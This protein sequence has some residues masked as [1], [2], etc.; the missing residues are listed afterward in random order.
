MTN[1]NAVP[2]PQPSESAP[3]ASARPSRT[4]SFGRQAGVF[5][6]L[7]AVLL[8]GGYFRLLNLDWDEGEHLHPDER[9]MTMVTGAIR[10]PGPADQF[11]SPPPG[12]ESW[13]G[14]FDSYCSPLNP[15]SHD[16]FGSYAYGTFPLF[17]A[18]VAGEWLSEACVDPND[19]AAHAPALQRWLADL[20]FDDV[21]GCV[22][23]RFTGYG[24]IH[25]IGRVLSALADLGAAALLFFIGRRLYGQGVGWL[26]TALYALAAL[27]IQQSHFYTVDSF[28]GFF[29]VAAGY[30]VVRGS[31]GGSWLAF[32]LAG[33]TFGLALACKVSVWPFAAVIALAA[34]L[35]Y[36]R[37]QGASHLLDGLMALLLLI[38]VFLIAVVALFGIWKAVN[39]AFYFAVFVLFIGAVAFYVLRPGESAHRRISVDGVLLRVVLAGVCA[40]FA[41]RVAQPYA[42]VGTDFDIQQWQAPEYDWLRTNVPKIW[43]TLED[44]LPTPIKVLFLP[45]PR[46]IS[47]LA[48]VNKQLTGEADVPWG[49]QWTNRLPFVFPWVNMVVWGMGLPLG[50]AVWIAWAVAGWQLWRGKNR[51]QHFIPWAWV[52]VLFFYQGTQWVKSIRYLLPIYPFLILLGA[53]LVVRVASGKWRVASGELARSCRLLSAVYRLPLAVVLVGTLLWAWG[54][55]RIYAH[56]VTRNTASRWMVENIPTAAT[57]HYEVDGET[58]TQFLRLPPTFVYGEDG[59]SHL[60]SFVMPQ[61]GVVTGVTFT[62]LSDPESDATPETFQVILSDASTVQSVLARSERTLQLEQAQNRLGDAHFFELQVSPLQGGQEYYLITQV[63]GGAPVGTLYGAAAATL[64][65]TAGGMTKTQAV[66]FPSTPH[67]L[68]NDKSFHVWPFTLPENGAV[69]GVTFHHLEDP[70]ADVTTEHIKVALAADIR[71]RV[72]LAQAERVLDLQAATVD[73]QDVQH[74]EFQPPALNGDQEYYLLTQVVSGAP[75]QLDT[76]VIANEYPDDSLPTRVDGR[77]P[78]GGMYRGLQSAGDG[79]THWDLNEDSNKLSQALEWLD[80]AD[81]IALSSNRGYASIPRLPSRYPL[82]IEFYR[83]LF[84][85]ELGFELIAT[86]TSYP[87]I[88]PFQFPDQETPFPPGEPSL[89]NHELGTISI[90]LPP[91]EEAFSVY[92][93]PQVF[94]FLKTADY[95]R[96]RVEEILGRVKLDEM[97]WQKPTEATLSP[98]A[99]ML[100]AQE[101]ETQRSGGTWTDI[102]DA[103]DWLNRSPLLAVLVWWMLAQAVGLAAF[104]LLFVAAPGLR[105]RGWPLAKTLGLLLLATAAWLPASLKWL[106]YSR[107]LIFFA[108]L[109][110]TVLGSGA[111]WRRRR[112]IFRWAGRERR[113]ILVSELLFGGMY[114]A[115]L[116]VRYGNPDLWHPVMGGER[117]MDFAYL[118]AVIKSTYFPPY[119]PWF[120]GG[121]MNYYYFGFVIAGTPVKLLGLLPEIAYNLILPTFFALTGAGAYSVA[122]NLAASRRAPN[123]QYPISN[124]QSP[125]R[126]GLVAAIFVA[127][128]GNLAE[129]QVIAK[130]LYDLGARSFHFQSTIPGL[131]ELVTALRGLVKAVIGGEAMPWR[132]EWPYWNPSR[133]IPYAA[134]DGTPPITEFPFFTFLYSDLHAH[135]LVLPLTLLALGLLASWVLDGEFWLLASRSPGRVHVRASALRGRRWA[136][137][138]LGLVITGLVIGSLYPTNTWD[139]VTYLALTPLALLA[140]FVV[141]QVGAQGA[142]LDWTTVRRGIAA[143][144]GR[145]AVVAG[146]SYVFFLPYTSRY[147][148]A[149][150]GFELWKGSKTPLWAYF[151]VHGLFLWPVLTW[152]LVKSWASW[153]KT[154][155]SLRVRA[156]AAGFAMATLFAV[157]A[158][159]A[160]AVIVLPFGF[161]ALLILTRRP[162]QP[163]ERFIALLVGAALALTLWVEGMVLNQGDVGRMNTVFKFYLQAW[164]LFGVS[165]AVC[166]TWL[167]RG[168][169]PIPNIAARAWK[170]ILAALV[171]LAALY[172]IFATR[173]KIYDRWDKSVGPGLNSLEWMKHIEDVQ[174]GPGAPEGLRFSLQWDYDALMWLRENVAGSPAVM[175]GAKA[176]AYRSL[177]DRVATYTGLPIVIG[178]DWHQR[179]QRSFLKVDLI[180]R[181]IADVNLFYDTPDPWLARQILDRYAVS[182]VYLGD[183]ERVTYDPAGIQKFDQ[184]EQTGLLRPV[185]ENPGVTIYQ[186]SQ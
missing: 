60:A 158:G 159:Y 103:A 178:Y 126:A 102:F 87:T 130:G 59:A 145:F 184:M 161:L 53:W 20:L 40:F 25:V 62:H 176:Q 104:P 77:D 54:F 141:H 72:V 12:C 31:Q 144:G 167:A 163:A 120:A 100:T 57:L 32:A 107:P 30:L 169:H 114:V 116:L 165:A 97:V 148:T 65:Y 156:V 127:V 61:D 117:P 39:L 80:E 45:D 94:I 121:A 2:Q 138:L 6:S 105:D 17:A 177:R 173:A 82:A 98:T 50:L 68:V 151:V 73:P 129:I 78:F 1:S 143:V 185:Y 128:M 79:K 43:Y 142:G 8:V 109:L 24:H 67:I 95:S 175:E 118:N 150:T 137:A 85:E 164:V 26:A 86:F 18:R 166:L 149:S 160:V 36:V 131:A 139:Y 84:A 110:L 15:Y 48:S 108:L 19:P 157:T 81:V 132:P 74:F 111:A 49:H 146:L 55:S 162:T 3:S 147:A 124:P 28:A 11:S 96:L 134:G 38:L 14:Y 183:L 46:F 23:T 171:I 115:F 174:Y 186:V 29:I 133:A 52:A 21:E 76:T 27:P 10:T 119:D 89:I 181:R 88:G 16:G 7:L 170:T 37:E 41:F 9:Y 125:I 172:P 112:E 5:L 99:L 44:K 33:L 22:G 35:Y 122:Y 51:M 182:Y 140:G 58:R 70:L 56:P 64:Q 83:A 34:L 123:T 106:P 113:T 75:V 180:G 101:T 4:T 13:G 63:T 168:E 42:F 47:T 91:A 153:R 155:P 66:E 90:D 179:Q 152:L 69:T 154:N 93:H 135:L 92:D 71:G 136:S